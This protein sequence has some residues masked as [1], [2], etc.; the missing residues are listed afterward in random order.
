M[1]ELQYS[2]IPYLSNETFDSLLEHIDAADFH[3][4]GSNSKCAIIDKYAILKTT[5]IPGHDDS[6]IQIIKTLH[7]L[8]NEDIN[9][10]PILGYGI[11][12]TGT[13]FH[14]GKRYDKGY[15]IQEKAPG[16]EL[17]SPSELRDK[18]DDEKHDLIVDYL[19]VLKAIPQ[20]HFDKWI[21][22]F[23][24]ITDEKVMI[25]P[26]KASNF[27]YDKKKGFSFIDLNF[28]MPE[29]LFDRVD[30]NGQQ[31]HAEFILYSLTP[32]RSLLGESGPYYKY[33]TPEELTIA[34]KIAIDCFN[35]NMSALK[36]VGVTDAD[37]YYCA[38][39]YNIPLPKQLLAQLRDSISTM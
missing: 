34:N 11:E 10:V 32:F 12:Q 21:T 26:S 2:Y 27:F 20:E 1:I 23:K 4:S 13:P 18:T 33:L 35:K 30:D 5:N 14:N 39:K 28:F 31:H 25:D 38:S 37:I 19:K 36:K 22:D 29:N 15:I 6:F 9:V 3:K 8:K 17:L 24:A 7:Q 16:K